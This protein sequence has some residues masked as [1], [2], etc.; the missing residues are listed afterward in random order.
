[1]RWLL[2]WW[3]VLTF[4][5]VHGLCLTWFVAWWSSKMNSEVRVLA[6]GLTSLAAKVHEDVTAFMTTVDK[7][8]TEMRGTMSESFREVRAEVKELSGVVTDMHSIV[9]RQAIHDRQ[10]SALFERTEDLPGIR[11][12]G[13]AALRAAEKAQRDVD[14]LWKRQRGDS[15]RFKAPS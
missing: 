2:D 11:V 14:E 1:M 9:D 8:I 12:E 15:G 6:E 7:A 10:I 5:V 13:K 4:F 3:P